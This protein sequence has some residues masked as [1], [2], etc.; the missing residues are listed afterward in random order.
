VFLYQDPI[1][2]SRIWDVSHLLDFR[3]MAGH[4]FINVCG[5]SP[6]SASLYSSD[7]TGTKADP[8]PQSAEAT[9]QHRHRVHRAIHESDRKGLAGRGLAPT[10]QAYRAAFDKVISEIST[11][12]WIKM[13]DFWTFI[14]NTVGAAEIEALFGPSLLKLHPSF[15]RDFFDF[16][17]LTPWL[18]KGL[19]FSRVE[20]IRETLL[21]D[22]RVWDKCVRLQPPAENVFDGQTNWGSEWTQ[23]R[24]ETFPE[25]FDANAMAS[26]DLGVVW[27][28]VHHEFF[29][30]P[31]LMS[32]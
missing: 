23:Y 10:F 26:H 21:E 27:G 11:Q 5:M 24:H 14:Q 32:G 18:L 1:T 16:D 30:T 17:K 31:R 20:R 22:L 6:E 15:L 19:S 4:F 2:I 25:F 9:V 7:T 3:P 29:H 8:V 28:F 12:E 13:D